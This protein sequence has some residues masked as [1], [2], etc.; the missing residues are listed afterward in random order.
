MGFVRRMDHF[1]IVTDQPD[2]TKEFY[3][4][5]GLNPGARP[6]F[7]VAGFW[8]YATDTPIL[9]VIQVKEMP[10]PVRGGLD[11]MAFRGDGLLAVLESLDARQ[12]KYRL[13]RAPAPFLTWQLFCFDPNG[14]EVEM[15]FDPTEAGPP[16]EIA[17]AGQMMRA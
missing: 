9:H 8:L 16:G 11:H 5:L 10:K 12:I 3:A 6:N 15:D 13:T 1:T 7:Q 2:K 17:T 14:I 4:A